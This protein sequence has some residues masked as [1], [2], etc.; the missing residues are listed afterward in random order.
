MIVMQTMK[1]ISL[2]RALACKI[3]FLSITAGFFAL[4]SSLPA[5]VTITTGGSGNGG[6]AHMTFS[7][8]VTFNVTGNANYILFIIDEAI[9]P[10]AGDGSQS[11]IESTG[12]HYDI[13]GGIA[14]SINHWDDNLARTVGSITAADSFFQATTSGSVAVGDTV[15][16]HAGTLTFYVPLSHPQFTVFPSGSYSM[17]LTDGVGNV[18][19]GP[20][21]AVPESGAY[22]LLTAA[23]CVCFAFLRRKFST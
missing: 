11:G 18:I 14:Y 10:P 13:N 4:A 5:A 6:D 2:F 8:D 9:N 7:Q 1:T 23:V 3:Q 17:F 19:S 15:T 22:A 21:V 12:L 20:G 16:L